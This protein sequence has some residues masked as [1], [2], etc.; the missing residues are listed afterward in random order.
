MAG[1]AQN[2][3]QNRKERTNIVTVRR[4]VKVVARQYA[5]IKVRVD[6]LPPPKRARIVLILDDGTS[7]VVEGGLES[8]YI[9]KA[10]YKVYSK[11]VPVV[12][13]VKDRI[14]EAR[15]IGETERP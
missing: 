12:E 15:L 5:R 11:F 7:V 8:A 2:Q 9:D 3:N 1:N 13:S 6:R 14:R 4:D 10:Y